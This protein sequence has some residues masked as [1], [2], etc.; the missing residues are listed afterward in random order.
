V[1]LAGRRQ[2]ERITTSGAS[3]N[4]VSI[5]KQQLMQEQRCCKPAASCQLVLPPCTVTFQAALHSRGS[6]TN[7]R[8]VGKLPKSSLPSCNADHWQVSPSIVVWLQAEQCLEHEWKWPCQGISAN[9]PTLREMNHLTQL[10]PK[11]SCR[12][13]QTASSDHG[14]NSLQVTINHV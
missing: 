2:S 4:R 12:G 3:R 6:E 13:R 9:W 8:T 5:P 7:W 1:S 11:C 14:E 10:S